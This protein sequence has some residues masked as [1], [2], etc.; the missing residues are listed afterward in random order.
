MFLTFT[1][2][3][4]NHSYITTFLT[5]FSRHNFK[6]TINYVL[7]NAITANNLTIDKYLSGKALIAI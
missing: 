6:I 1:M 2:Q 3:H 5:T 4:K 7:A